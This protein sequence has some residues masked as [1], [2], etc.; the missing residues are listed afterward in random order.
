ALS[1]PVWIRSV[2]VD[3]RLY[4]DLETPE[5]PTHAQNI[6]INYTAPSLLVPQRVRFRYK[7]EG[8]DKEW[9]DAGTRR[10]AFYSK[11][12]PG[13]YTFRVTASNNDGLW[14]EAGASFVVT[15]PPSFPQS[16]LFESLCAVAVFGLLWLLYTIR[17]RQFTAQVKARFYERLA[18]GTENAP[19][20]HETLLESFQGVFLT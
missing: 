14:S 7:L 6:E 4:N 5:F 2:S 19:R 12:P 11:L 15:I 9:H 20:V 13:T 16:V 17:L 8:F 18:G 3:T 1:P 10:Q